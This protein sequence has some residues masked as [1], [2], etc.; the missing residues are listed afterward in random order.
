MRKRRRNRN[1]FIRIAIFLILGTLSVAADFVSFMLRDNVPVQHFNS[2]LHKKEAIAQKNLQLMKQD[3]LDAAENEKDFFS[4]IDFQKLSEDDIFYYVIENEKLI[5]WSDNRLD[6]NLLDASNLQNNSFVDL[7]NASCLL[8][9]D[10]VEQQTILA[11][12]KIKNKFDVTNKYISNNFA[13]DFTHKRNLSINPYNKE[14][15]YQVKTQDGTFLFSLEVASHEKRDNLWLL[16]SFIFF[17]LT[18]LSYCNLFYNLDLVFSKRLFEMKNFVFISIAFL[19][20]PVLLLVFKLPTSIFYNNLFNPIYYSGV[21]YSLGHLVTFS[22]LFTTICFTF[23]IKVN[24]SFNGNKKIL[25]WVLCTAFAILLF[26]LIRTI[27]D[28]IYNSTFDILVFQLDGKYT[29]YSFYSLLAVIAVFLSLIYVARRILFEIRRTESLKYV[30]LVEFVVSLVGFLLF[31]AFKVSH[32]ALIAGAFFSILI[33]VNIL[34][35][36]EKSISSVI[37]I[38]IFSYFISI[39]FVYYAFQKHMD[40][41]YKVAHLI[42]ENLIADKQGL[43][44]PQNENMTNYITNFDDL[45]SVDRNIS[46]YVLNKKTLTNNTNILRYIQKYCLNDLIYSIYDVKLQILPSNSAAIKDYQKQ[47]SLGNF[48]QISPHVVQNTQ[49]NESLVYFGI[50]YYTENSNN[51]TLVIRIEKKINSFEA[52]SLPDDIFENS[53]QEQIYSY[54]VYR[55]HHLVHKSGTYPYPMID[56]IIGN[57]KLLFLNDNT[58]YIF[59]YS[60]DT[61]IVV[62]CKWFGSTKTFVLN[63]TYIALAFVLVILL[64]VAFFQV[65]GKPSKSITSSL[66]NTFLYTILVAL[67]VVLMSLFYVVYIEY[68]RVFMF[69]LDAKLKYISTELNNENQNNPEKEELLDFVDLLSKKYDVD[70]NLYSAEG[71]LITSTRPYVFSNG[72]SSNLI[73]SEYFFGSTSSK[74]QIEESL[75]TLK[76]NCAFSPIYDKFGEIWAYVKI[77]FFLSNSLVWSDI[78]IFMAIVINVF[79]VIFIIALFILFWSNRRIN[80][81]VAKFENSMKLISFVKKNEKINIKEAQTIDEVDKLVKQYNAMVDEIDAS[82]RLLAQ[83]ERENAW[84]EMAQQVAHEIKNPLTPM[85]LS[86]QQ[87]LRLKEKNSPMFEENFKKMSKVLIEQIDDMAKIANSFSNFSKIGTASMT[88]VDLIDRLIS[89]VELFKNNDKNVKISFNS[90]MAEAIVKTNSTQIIEVF[91]NLVKNAIQAIPDGKKGEIEIII[92]QNANNVEIA[93]KDNGCGIDK[94]AQGDIFT[95]HF[96][97]KTHGSGLGLSIAKNI[98]EASHGKIWF[99]TKIN[100]GTTFFVRLPLVE[101]KS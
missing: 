11:L 59:R 27:D 87:L 92:R 22:L 53:V 63:F 76:Y 40:N 37:S 80:A 38:L 89:V 46:D 60:D 50:F 8:K 41:Q 10:T 30:L 79:F 69:N 29:K 35:Y 91:N 20:A 55:Q 15:E 49:I 64:L 32:G 51:N 100:H 73:N 72:F 25:C 48:T 4:T 58:H 66:Q 93:V 90:T 17:F 98:V 16:I 77:V 54:A 21:F 96:S 99:E 23:Y 24:F 19:A 56:R 26:L 43:F 6:I 44:E 39:F 2:V 7:R 68:T 36:V 57:S 84:R 18:L 47:I 61:E 31:L 86:I 81:T 45:V 82:A 42:S 14:S 62:S 74:I 71:E 3:V 97:T 13:E 1:F 34:S 88:N 94:E 28:I 83:N 70:V 95:P 65:K 85:R 78:L 67:A 52:Y 75:G 5:F 12:I 101:T 9:C 33:A